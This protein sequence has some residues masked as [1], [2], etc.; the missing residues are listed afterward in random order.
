MVATSS[1]SYCRQMCTGGKFRCVCRKVPGHNISQLPTL[2]A[3]C[4]LVIKDLALQLGCVT[5]GEQERFDGL[6]ATWAK[7]R[8]D[9]VRLDRSRRAAA[10]RQTSPLLRDLCSA[11]DNHKKQCGFKK[12]PPFF[13][14]PCLHKLPISGHFLTSWKHLSFTT[15]CSVSPADWLHILWRCMSLFFFS[16][17][18]ICH[19]TEIL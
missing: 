11:R 10:Y 12:T 6:P 7:N 1:R 18:W 8:A 4:R 19:L 3:I 5:E 15:S 2:I 16:F 9:T 13:F 17:S 14:T